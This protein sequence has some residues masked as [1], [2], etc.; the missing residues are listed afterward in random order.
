MKPVV[1][2]ERTG[3][4]IASVAA[5]AGISYSKARSIANSLGIRAED[6]TLWS[7]TSYVRRLLRHFGFAGSHRECPFRSWNAL[8]NFA[9]LSI[10]WHLEQGRP[11]WHWVVFV[12]EGGHAYV[13]DSKKSL[14]KNQRTDFGRMKPKWFIPVTDAQQRLP[15]DS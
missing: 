13:L 3:C 7:D 4:G 5:I 10:K 15:A 12:R 9:L 11:Y 8:P 14:R 2:L 6:K 1:Q